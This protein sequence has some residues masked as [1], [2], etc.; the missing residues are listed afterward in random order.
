MHI[1]VVIIIIKFTSLPVGH[2]N[3]IVFTFPHNVKYKLCQ[4]LK[5][6]FIQ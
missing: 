1:V 6:I 3:L 2:S 5:L 4:L